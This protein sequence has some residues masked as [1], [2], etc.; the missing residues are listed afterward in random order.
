MKDARDLVRALQHKL[1]GAEQSLESERD[2]YNGHLALQLLQT[3]Q[4]LTHLLAGAVTI[5]RRDACPEAS[6]P[7]EVSLAELANIFAQRMKARASIVIQSAADPCLGSTS[8]LYDADVAENVLDRLLLVPSGQVVDDATW[9]IS[10]G[11]RGMHAAIV[12]Q[13]TQRHLNEEGDSVEEPDSQARL[14]TPSAGAEQLEI[15]AAL[16]GRIGAGLD[17]ELTNAG[18][19]E[20]ALLWPIQAQ[21]TSI[22][23]DE[24]AGIC[25]ADPS[26]ASAR[27]D[28]VEVRNNW[29]GTMAIQSD[30]FGSVEIDAKDIIQF[31]KGIIGFPDDHGFVLIR[32]TNAQAVGWLQSVSNPGLALPVVSA[33][34]LT[35][36]Y[37]DV[38]IESYAQAAGLGNNL[39]ELAVVVVL[40][41]QPSVPATVNLVA[42]IIVN[43]TTRVGAQVLL[44]GSRFTTREMF[45]LPQQPAG[46]AQGIEASSVN[47]A[48]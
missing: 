31:P 22:R 16:L 14:R 32:T 2:T 23:D 4:L 38:D 3:C 11:I 43:V 33:H 45:I 24:S 48:Q 30:R 6:K 15:C 8:I 47:A 41:A 27:A 39:E 28:E 25:V 7:R 18:G 40:N 5:A 12:L 9:S 42:P 46:A 20:F 10:V 19:W 36:Q 35:P 29:S 17:F 44:D 13:R 34:V 37:P 21:G 26:P 1:T